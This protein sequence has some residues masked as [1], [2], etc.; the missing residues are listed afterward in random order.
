MSTNIVNKMENIVNNF[1]SEPPP[2]G[3]YLKHFRT[4]R[5]L[6]LGELAKS[7]TI[8][9][10]MLSQI[11][12]GKVNPTLVTLWKIA[13]ALGVDISELIHGTGG[14]R[15]FFYRLGASEQACIA[16]ADGQ[17]TFRILTAPGLP[18]HLEMYRVELAPGAEHRSEAHSRGCRELVLVESGTVRVTAGER[19]AVLQAGDFLAY[20]GDQVHTLENTG[21]VPARLHMTDLNPGQ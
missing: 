7:S 4:G 6:S 19:E 12:S 13:G 20:R 1:R 11:E 21:A 9:K 5:K 15:E 16:A 17:V 10:T 18:D 3:E 14:Q 8:S 2:V